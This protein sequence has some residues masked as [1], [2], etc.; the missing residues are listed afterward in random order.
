MLAFMDALILFVKV[1]YL[2]SRPGGMLSLFG[3]ISRVFSISR[4][5]VRDRCVLMPLPRQVP[6]CPHNGGGL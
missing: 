4:S 1:A 5:G 6:G 3:F 2:A